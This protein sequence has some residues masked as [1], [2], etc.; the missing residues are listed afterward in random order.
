MD[1]PSSIGKDLTLILVLLV[2]VI[3]GVLIYFNI[4]GSS[5]MGRVTEPFAATNTSNVTSTL[6]YAPLSDAEINVTYY[7]S[8]DTTWYNV[9]STNWTRTGRTMTFYALNATGVSN[10]DSNLSQVRYRY[11]TQTGVIVRDN[12]DPTSQTV[13]TLA[14]ILAIIVIA[15]IILGAVVV[16]GKAGK[17]GGI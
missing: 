10:Y 14:P 17:G 6:T 11:Y 1:A 7:N 8:S 12:V 15:G 3:I 9:P 4:S 5:E 2:T 13:F 16:F